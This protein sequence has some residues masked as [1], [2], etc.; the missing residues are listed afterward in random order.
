MLCACVHVHVCRE[1]CDKT[2]NDNDLQV[3]V[4]A[5][6]LGWAGLSDKGLTSTLSPK[7]KSLEAKDNGLIFIVPKR[8]QV[9][10]IYTLVCYQR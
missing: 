5:A 8:R 3:Q 1:D 9:P 2:V 10:M 6:G 7:S 4:W